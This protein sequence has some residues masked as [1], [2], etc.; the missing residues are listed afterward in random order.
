MDEA[1]EESGFRGGKTTDGEQI[2]K[3]RLNHE[4]GFGQDR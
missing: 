2:Q 3:R 4:S 1:V